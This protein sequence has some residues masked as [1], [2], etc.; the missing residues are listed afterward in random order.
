LTAR[1][2]SVGR[3]HR[4]SDYEFF[5]Y[6]SERPALGPTKMRALVTGGA[7]FIGSHLCDELLAR[8]D[9]VWCLDNLYLGREEN[10]CHLRGKPS[11]HFRKAD[12][13]EPGE[14]EPVFAESRPEIVYHLAANS[15]IS[16]GNKDRSLDLRLNFLTTI[17]VLEAMQRHA[18]KRVFFASTSAVFGDTR[19]LLRE[20]T[21]PLRPVSFYGA[22]KLAAEAYLSV[23]AQSLG[24]QVWI[25]R[26]P[27]VVGERCTHGAVHDFVARL[28]NDPSRLEV[29]G[30]GSQ[31][32]P[33]LYV[34][35]LV[36]AILTVCTPPAGAPTDGPLSVYHVAGEGLTSVSRIVEIV[37][38]E[39]ELRNTPVVYVG[40]KVG[41]V[42]DVPYFNYD[43][44]K[45]KS[46]GFVHRHDS[47]ESVRIAVRRI[48][49]KD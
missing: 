39:M 31:T 16:L 41:W 7:G 15:D 21:G 2:G 18:V 4:P 24:G 40:G 3:P 34:R 11:F 42:G 47:T 12:I 25:L 48:L 36:R 8:G 22:S 35:D 44:G 30:D 19:E 46:L 26:F 49:G 23:F 29:L 37:L 45:I 6:E 27:N 38:E 5:R 1:E 32:K 14:L 10:V 20:E 28:R 33:Y 43:S 9:E 13:L 17:E